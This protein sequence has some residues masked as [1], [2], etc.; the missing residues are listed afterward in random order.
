VRAKVRESG[1]GGRSETTGLG[2]VKQRGLK[3][4]VKEMDE[5]SGEQ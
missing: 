2:F 5:Q 1:P 3:P 4:G